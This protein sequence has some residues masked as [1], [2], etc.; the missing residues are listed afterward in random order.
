MALQV[1]FVQKYCSCTDDFFNPTLIGY[2]QREFEELRQ[3]GLSVYDTLQKMKVI[4]LCCRENLFNVSMIFLNSSNKAR[5][6]DEVGLLAPRQPG[7]PMRKVETKEDTP[8]ILPKKPLPPL[9]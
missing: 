4:R 3:S 2:R 5:L 6:T 1:P 8:K 9:P 7:R